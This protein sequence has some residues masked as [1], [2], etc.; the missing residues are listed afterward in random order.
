M[1]KLLMIKTYLIFYYFMQIMILEYQILDRFERY[2]SIITISRINIIYPHFQGN[3]LGWNITGALT[4]SDKEFLQN[5]LC[6]DQVHICVLQLLL[7]ELSNV[8]V[9]LVAV[10]T[11]DGHFQIIPQL[12][13]S[14]IYHHNVKYRLNSNT[15]LKSTIFKSTKF[16]SNWSQQ[17][18]YIYIFI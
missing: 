14:L 13:M 4:V 1:C 10:S 3:W 2:H 7:L 18:W 12:P 16:K 9:Q 5:F 15:K 6:F 8:V 17:L 11:F